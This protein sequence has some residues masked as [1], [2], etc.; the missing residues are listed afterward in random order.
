MKINI[1]NSQK[2]IQVSICKIVKGRIKKKQ[3][4]FFEM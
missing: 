1:L 4:R 3:F 2:K